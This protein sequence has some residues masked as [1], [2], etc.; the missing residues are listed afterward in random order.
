MSATPLAHYVRDHRLNDRPLLP[1]V[2]SLEMLLAG[3][4]QALGAP[5]G[6]LRNLVFYRPAWASTNGSLRTRIRCQ[7]RPQGLLC[8]LYTALPDAPPDDWQEH[9]AVTA[10]ATTFPAPAPLDLEAVRARCTHE[11]EVDDLYRRVGEYGLQYGP[12]MRAMRRLVHNGTEVLAELRVPTAGDDEAALCRLHPA[13]LDASLQALACLV[14]DGVETGTGI[15]LPFAAEEV[16]IYAP[17]QGRAYG[18]GRVFPHEQPGRFTAEVTLTDESGGILVELQ[19]LSARR[20]PA[21]VV[22][23]PRSAPATAVASPLPAPVT[24]R[25]AAQIHRPVWRPTSLAAEA[26]LTS[27]SLLVFADAAGVGPALAR[28]LTAE[29][30]ITLVT[31]GPGFRAVSERAFEVNPDNPDDYA[32]LWQALIARQEMPAEI[33]HCWAC[34]AGVPGTNDLSAG[35]GDSFFSLVHLVRTL[36]NAKAGPDLVLRVV[37]ADS[38]MTAPGD[39]CTRPMS[40]LAWGLARVLGLEYRPWRVQCLDTTLTD[41]G[42]EQAAALLLPDLAAP[43]C[44]VEVAFRKGQRLTPTEETVTSAECAALPSPV[45]ADGVYLITGGLGGIGLALAEWLARRGGSLRLILAGRTVLSAGGETG[46]AAEDPSTR[47]RLEAVSRLEA[48]GA[49]VE[50]VA[51]DVG[52]VDAVRRLVADIRERHGRLDAIFHS[53]GVLRDGLLQGKQLASV[54]DVFRPKV[55]GALALDAARDDVP[56]V[57]FSSVVGWLGNVGQADYAAANRFLDS[58]AAHCAAQGR[59]THC[60]AW[61]PW[62]EVGMAAGMEPALRARGIELLEPRAALDALGLALGST[63]PQLSIAAMPESLRRALAPTAV[64]V[65]DTR[66]SSHLSV[67]DVQDYLAR[68]LAGFLEVDV[69]HITPDARFQ[70]F[71]V[72]SI[73]AVQMLHQIESS[74]GLSLPPTLLF[75]YPDLESFAGYLHQT[76]P[77]DRL[78]ALLRDHPLPQKLEPA[79]GPSAPPASPLPAPVAPAPSLQGEATLLDGADEY[80]T[81]V[82]PLLS[83]RLKALRLDKCYLWGAG[84]YLEYAEGGQRVRVLDML[85]GYGTTLFGHNH[86]ELVGALRD[87]LLAS[88]PSHTQVSLRG[89]SG[90]LARKLSACVSAF[91]GRDYVAVFANSGA[92]AIE[93]ALKHAGMEFRR[94]AEIW[95]RSQR[96]ADSVLLH[97]WANRPN[98]ILSDHEASGLATIADLEGVD[99]GNVGGLLLALERRN[100]AALHS[101]PRFLAVRRSF[102]GKT[103]GALRLTYNPDYQVG[104]A[105]ASA[106]VE[107]LNPVDVPGVREAVARETH[108]L[109]TLAEDGRGGL[110]LKRQSWCSIAAAFVEPIQGEGGVQQLDSRLLAELRDLADRHGFPLVVDEVQSGM[111]RCGAF[112]AAE[113]VGLRGD[114]YAFGKAL[115]GGLTKISALLIERHRYVEEFGIAHSSTFAEDDPSALVALQALTLLERDGLPARCAAWGAEVIEGLCQLRREFPDVIADVRG[116][117]CMLGV[118][119]VEQ[120]RSPSALFRQVGPYL[121]MLAASYLLNVHGIRLLPTT[122]APLTLRLEPSAYVSREDGQRCLAA[123]KQFCLIVSRANAGRLVRHLVDSVE[124][125]FGPVADWSNRPIPEDV[126][127]EPGEPKVAFF[128][129][130]I[131]PEDV[132]WW[133]PSLQEVPQERHSELVRRFSRVA[134]PGVARRKRIR[135][136]TGASVCVE[137][138]GFLAT[139]DHLA[140]ALQ[141]DDLEWLR[142]QIDDQVERA[143][144]DGIRAVGFGGFLSIV[145]H[146]A[147][148]AARSDICLTTGNALTVSSGLEL[149][150]RGCRDRG[151]DLATSRAAVVGAYGNIG[152]TYARLIAEEAGRILL[153]G[154]PQS[155]PR[156]RELAAQLLKDAWDRL[157]CAEGRPA[158]G[159]AGELL[160]S[161]AVRARLAEG[162]LAP[163]EAPELLAQVD[164]E[165]GED[166]PLGISTDLH[167]LSR[168]RAVLTAS[169]APEPIIHPEHLAAGPVVICDVAV[170]SDVGPAVAR[171]RPDV[172]VISGG[173]VRLP[174][175]QRPGLCGRHLPAESV[176]ACLGE[177]LLL[178]LSG[179]Q[180]HFSF[181]PI[182]RE[183]VHVIASLARQHGFEPAV[184][185]VRGKEW[186]A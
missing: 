112:T 68:R 181:G 130:F 137:I 18:Y 150:R 14:P 160:R 123:L 146:N 133:E 82:R 11:A 156:L 105:P 114:Y 166:A 134:P 6:R 177:T 8:Q 141:A 119:L 57:L 117:G 13:L 23:P 96:Q 71:G 154:R 153:I 65:S 139:S 101:S 46:L 111:G 85:G 49:K 31:R 161:A 20:I 16:R 61:G 90:R 63:S 27:G 60:I 72:D 19:G 100:N 98:A 185:G 79:A 99:T 1:G 29:R 30:V 124:D 84:D 38:Q 39:P 81:S 165:L 127:A 75:D 43:P 148:R 33:V 42:P 83:Q 110:T 145:T 143:V 183:N 118:E 128:S 179:W 163:G 175:G 32:S 87:A 182:S 152:S 108:S 12:S 151:I 22:S 34:D 26:A 80:A 95:R 122:S 102:H 76:V 70:D 88:V 62:A 47:R 3:A 162:A 66:A 69:T 93:A 164:R 9:A 120:S 149:W 25:S 73:S 116:R 157:L 94:R 174:L 21:G 36:R 121:G 135:S 140:E 59:P 142:G 89:A 178:G 180:S 74:T 125:P 91:T 67:A 78:E 113:G 10:E 109:L 172:L 167:D 169:N 186:G 171:E 54:A 40:A 77:H 184:P 176:F 28:A 115:G 55:S 53:A 132:L 86:P 7:H 51:V 106:E 2:L 5:V 15:Y 56:L 129:Y 44:D 170:P 52:D 107:F 155:R 103:A 173:E 138:V 168:C 58:F 131:E 158:R 45:R 92:E 104:T 97:T 48:L 24:D 126:P 159:V 144:H 17:L 37:T 136:A 35:V 147:V 50:S 64:R 4:N 41:A